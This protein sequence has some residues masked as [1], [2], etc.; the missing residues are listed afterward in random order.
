MALEE[1]VTRLLVAGEHEAAKNRRLVVIFTAFSLFCAL[2]AFIF[3]ALGDSISYYKIP[4]AISQ[5]DR[6]TGSRLRL[7]GF[8]VAGSL[9]Q[10][11]SEITF[12]L[13]DDVAAEPIG[14][15]GIVPDLFREGQA[16]VVEGKFEA[17]RGFVAHR[18]LAKH[19]ARYISRER[20]DMLKKQGNWQEYLP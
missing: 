5:N 8:V 14:F 6:K 15:Q 7:G 13:S 17:T 20:A 1:H 9:K 18:L 10:H 4:S 16:V 3:Y 11:G 2:V 19:D 12:L